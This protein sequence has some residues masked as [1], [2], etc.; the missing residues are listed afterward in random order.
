M[1]GTHGGKLAK[2]HGAV[3]W[4]ELKQHL[5]PERT[6]G[7]LARVAG[8]PGAADETTPTALLSH[9]DWESVET[10]DQ[11]LRWTGSALEALGPAALEADLSSSAR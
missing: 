3:G 10:R 5:S 4:Y 9:F 8:L 6:C 11:L 1:P 2:L 7:L